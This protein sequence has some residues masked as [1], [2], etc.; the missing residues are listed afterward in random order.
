MSKTA[1]CIASGPSLCADDVEYC[2]GK[3][4]VYVV[5]D[6]Y[7]MA[8]WADVLYACDLPWWEHHSGVPGFAGE[9][10]TVDLE[11]S[12]KYGLNHIGTLHGEVWSSRADAI[13]TGR[14]S[15]FQALNLAA[16]SADRIILLGYDMKLGPNRERHWFGEHPGALNKNS[17]YHVFIKA[18]RDAAPHIKQKVINCS[19][20]T[21]LDCFPQADLRDVL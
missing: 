17:D 8:P 21:A 2:K 1:I 6:C 3:G 14:N 15:G 13:A 19:R 9:K 5:N 7:K 12:R 18:F 20:A 16:H 11:A 4:R 10:W